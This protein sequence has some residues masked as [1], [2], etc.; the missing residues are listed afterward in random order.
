MRNRNRKRPVISR[1]RSS[2][3]HRRPLLGPSH[4]THRRDLRDRKNCAD[5][6]A[7]LV[8]SDDLDFS[9]YKNTP[10]LLSARSLRM[11]N[12]P[13]S[14]NC[15]KLHFNLWAG[16]PLAVVLVTLAP[17]PPR[18]HHPALHLPWVR[19]H[20]C[21]TLQIFVK[22]VDVDIC[23]KILLKPRASLTSTFK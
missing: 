23:S 18:P 21:C 4:G 6:F 5:G 8:I 12:V 10:L 2:H 15:W 7:A 13:R 16:P 3:N 11:Q 14:R 9:D 22:F 17:P 20:F 19:K 1:A